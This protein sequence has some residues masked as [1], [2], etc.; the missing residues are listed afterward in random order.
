[1]KPCPYCAE[2]IQDQAAKCRYCGEWL[3][4]SKRPQSAR[5][6]LERIEL[7]MQALNRR[8]TVSFKT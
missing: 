3:D 5:E 8:E 7:A 6:F 2:L 4:P 1:M